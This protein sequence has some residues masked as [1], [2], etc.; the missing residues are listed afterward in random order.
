MIELKLL[1]RKEFE[2]ILNGKTIAG[3][4]CTWSMVRFAQIKNMSWKQVGEYLEKDQSPEDTA[5]SILCA[6]EYKSRKNREPFTYTEL[7][8]WEW[9]DEMGGVMSVNWINLIAHASSNLPDEEKKNPVDS[10][11]I[12][13]SKELLSEPV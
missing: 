1:P 4:Y 8:L 13:S 5:L 6:I 3:K 11:N 10:L 12:M 9:C 2:I 7:D